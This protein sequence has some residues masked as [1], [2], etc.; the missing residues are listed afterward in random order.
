MVPSSLEQALDRMSDGFVSV[1]ASWRYAYVNRYAEWY[2]GKPRAELL[3]RTLWEVF[4]ASRGTA[5]ERALLRAMASQEPLE[6]EQTSLVRPGV[7]H[8]RAFPASDGVSFYFREVTAQKAGDEQRRLLA[9]SVEVLASAL[10][11]EGRLAKVTELL[12]PRLADHCV[13]DV[14]EP[15][16]LVHA[17]IVNRDPTLVP[18]CPPKIGLAAHAY[19]HRVLASGKAEVVERVDDAWLREAMSEEAGR[20]VVRVLGPRSLVV[21]PLIADGVAMGVLTL[22]MVDE[23]RVFGATDLPFVQ[24][25]ADRVAAALAHARLHEAVLAARRQRDDTLAMVSHD[26]R[27]PLNVIKLYAQVIAR[28]EPSAPE[29]PA[30]LRAVERAD[31]LIGDLLTSA[32][33]DEGKLPLEQAPEELGLLVA[34]VTELQR[35]LARQRELTLVAEAPPP[36]PLVSIDRHRVAQVLT[37]LIANAIKFTPRGGHVTVRAR[38]EPGFVCVDVIDDGPGMDEET[39]ARVFDRFWQATRARHA[40]AGLGLA[41][42]KGIVDEHGGALR[43]SS[44]VGS[45]TTFTVALPC[46]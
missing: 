26:L 5:Q 17:A 20:D 35:P 42:A 12:V 10:S 6:F 33:L 19:A 45:G 22:I 29:P 13:I 3:G 2:L 46:T 44:S 34:E 11:F 23:R 9:E 8:F 30:I 21:A 32:R 18:R 24:L 40:G 27:A 37:N 4:P 7:F 25:I 14:L 39:R 38:R 36:L 43:V 1:D 28:R 31:A 15:R 41:I 16:G